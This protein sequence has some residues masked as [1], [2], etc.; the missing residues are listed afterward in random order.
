MPPAVSGRNEATSVHRNGV[1]HRKVVIAIS[2]ATTSAA[3]RPERSEAKSRGL[4]GAAEL[5]RG[6]ST[7]L[8]FGRDDG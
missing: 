1:D 5:K 2:R 8:R 6:P 3:R 4:F 7:P